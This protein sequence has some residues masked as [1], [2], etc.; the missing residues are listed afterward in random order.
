[1]FRE[2]EGPIC[3][4]LF[5]DLYLPLRVTGVEVWAPNMGPQAFL[6]GF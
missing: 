1:M 4:Y 6:V 3:I 2:K 5:Y